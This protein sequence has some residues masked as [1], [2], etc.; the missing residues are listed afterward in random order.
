MFKTKDGKCYYSLNKYIA[1]YFVMSRY[2]REI[3]LDLEK[4]F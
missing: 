2:V 3:K 4:G 1:Y